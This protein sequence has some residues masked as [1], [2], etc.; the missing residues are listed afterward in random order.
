MGRNVRAVGTGSRNSSPLHRGSSEEV[1]AGA[2][3]CRG[4]GVV[5]GGWG[6]SEGERGKRK[7]PMGEQ[8][9]QEACPWQS[10]PDEAGGWR[11]RVS[12]A[13]VKT[14]A[15]GLERQRP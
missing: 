15:M 7:Q 12:Q 2:Q 11:K 14:L 1:L 9:D 6:R 5:T 8:G 10:G 3:G 13:R 4:A